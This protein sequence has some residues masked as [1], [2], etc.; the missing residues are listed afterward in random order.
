MAF[1]SHVIFCRLFVLVFFFFSR[2]GFRFF[3]FFVFF[4]TFR[5]ALFRLFAWRYFGV[6]RRKTKLY[7][8]ATINIW[9]VL[10]SDAPF[11]KCEIYKPLKGL[12]Y[13]EKVHFHEAWL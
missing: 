1:F 9:Q 8:P 12:P 10:F 11:A 6:K 2:G 7:N 3:F 5:L 13:G 4:F